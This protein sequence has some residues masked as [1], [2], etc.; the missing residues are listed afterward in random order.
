[1]SPDCF[2]RGKTQNHPFTFIESRRVGHIAFQVGGVEPVEF[3]EPGN[4]LNGCTFLNSAHYRNGWIPIFRHMRSKAAT[5][6]PTML[7]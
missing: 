1:M 2:R 4:K 6:N 5:G 7:K 3:A